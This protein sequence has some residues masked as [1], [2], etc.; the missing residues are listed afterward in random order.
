MR[1]MAVF[2]SYLL[3]PVFMLTYIC[4][5]FL[6]TRNYFS[7]FMSPGKKIFLLAAVFIFSVALPLLN[8]ALLKRMGYIR[9]LQMND[10]SERFMPYVSSLV[11]HAGL[12]Y[13]IHDLD[14]PFFFKFMIIASIAVLVTVL[15]SNFFTRISAHA[16]AAGGSLAILVFYEFI[17]FSPELAPLCAGFALC[18]LI[19]FARLYLEAHTP[20]Q[21]YAGFL[22][23]FSS[24]LLCLIVLLFINYRL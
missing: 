21:V 19:C 24:S 14:L 8:V 7:Y 11:L 20:R 23:G 9:S 1:S 16:A 13:I 4:S 22:A 10:S 6:F 15:A 12:L 17:S 2:I 3:H 5:Y 18:G